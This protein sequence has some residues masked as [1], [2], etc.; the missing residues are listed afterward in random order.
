MLDSSGHRILDRIPTVI[1][2]VGIILLALV[3]LA[4]LASLGIHAVSA[5]NG[6]GGFDAFIET[7]LEHL[8]LLFLVLELFKITAAYLQSRSIVPVVMEAVL[9]AV[10]RKLVMLETAQEGFVPKSLALAGLVLSIAATWFLL[11]RIPEAHDPNP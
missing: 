2:W 5:F 1:E 10:A 9:V 11:S 6:H 3:T 4:V 8:L 7:G